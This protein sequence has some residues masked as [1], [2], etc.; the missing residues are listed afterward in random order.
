MNDEAEVHEKLSALNAVWI[1]LAR[2]GD[3]DAAWN[4][5]D[6][7]LTLRARL[8]CSQWPRHHQF[9]WRGE[10]LADKRVL[11]RCYHGLGDTIQFARFL[12]RLRAVAREVILWTQPKL[13]PL[14][15]QQRRGPHR[16]LPLHDG[17]P[18]VDCDVTIELAE[19]MHVL[20]VDQK[21]IQVESAYL[22]APSPRPERSRGRRVGIVWRAGEWSPHRSI[23]CELL[24]CL[25]SIAGVEWIVLQRGPALS[26]WK[27]GFGRV[28][29]LGG[30]LD[31]AR[32]MRGLDLLISVDTCS[33]HLAGALGVPVWTLLPFDSD[34]RW[35]ECGSDTPWYPT[36]RLFRQK[37]SGDWGGVLEEVM[38]ELQRGFVSMSERLSR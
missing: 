22:R 32:A 31:E 4:V 8:D 30:I 14:L 17:Y 23:P 25:E 21:L 38:E 35:M 7:A 29:D 12:P 24:S 20:R 3:F 26:E 28:P 33:A 27:H 16:L 37:Q 5:S 9:L 15:R 36:M 2:A 1:Q 10:P 13:I 19:L 11:V 6:E 34:W 18:S